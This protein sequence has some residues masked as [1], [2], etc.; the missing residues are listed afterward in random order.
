M[1]SALDQD[2]VIMTRPFAVEEIHI[3]FIYKMNKNSVIL[4]TLVGVAW[5]GGGGT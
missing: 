1:L 4:L 3:T 2:H 5:G